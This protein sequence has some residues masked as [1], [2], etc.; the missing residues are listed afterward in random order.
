MPSPKSILMGYVVP[1]LFLIAGVVVLCVG[2]RKCVHASA[3]TNWPQ[4]DGVIVESFVE[5]D[6]RTD[7]TRFAPRIVYEYAVGDDLHTAT[8]VSYGDYSASWDS[9]AREVVD[10]YPVGERVTVYYHPQDHDTAVLEPGSR[11][12]AYLVAVMG[13]LF[14]VVGARLIV[15][16]PGAVRKHI[17]ENGI[18]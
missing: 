8:T 13:L 10:R 15:Y 4:T 1:W 7:G 3:S 2:V 11:F 12:N 17:S 16:M 18:L 5:T 14:T 9:H 6:H